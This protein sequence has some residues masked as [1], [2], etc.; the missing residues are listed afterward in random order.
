MWRTYSLLRNVLASALIFTALTGFAQ[1]PEVPT[2]HEAIT[3]TYHGVAII[4]SPSCSKT[5]ARFPAVRAWTRAQNERTRAYF[6]RL[7]FAGWRRT[8]AVELIADESASYGPGQLP[9]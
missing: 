8:G 6:N 2:A 1:L 7:P 5:T 9:G 3:N 4:D